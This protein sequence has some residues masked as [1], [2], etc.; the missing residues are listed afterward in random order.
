MDVRVQSEILAPGVQHRQHADLGTEVSRV[1]GHLDKG[2]RG[3]PHQQAADRAGVG[4]RRQA[5]GP[6]EHEDDVE[7]RRVEQVGGLGLQ[8]PRRGRGLALGAM[9]VAARVV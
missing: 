3:G 1:R 6:G 2:S 9:A 8:P 4:K 7:V 5:E